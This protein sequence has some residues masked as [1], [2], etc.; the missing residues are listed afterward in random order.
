MCIAIWCFA[1]STKERPLRRMDVAPV[2]L[3][4]PGIGWATQREVNSFVCMPLSGKGAQWLD[5]N[6]HVPFSLVDKQTVHPAGE[7]CCRS[8]ARKN[9]IWQAVDKWGKISGRLRLSDVDFY[10]VTNCVESQFELLSGNK[11]ARLY[12]SGR[13][14]RGSSNFSW[15]PTPRQRRALHS[16]WSQTVIATLVSS[17]RRAADSDAF[18]EIEMDNAKPQIMFFFTNGSGANKSVR[19]FWAVSG[20]PTMTIWWLTESGWSLHSQLNGFSDEAAQFPWHG[21]YRPLA[22]FDINGDGVPNIVVHEDQMNVFWRDILLGLT[23]GKW[24]IIAGSTG[25]ST[26]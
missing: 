25:G 4:S 13:G 9:S 14:Y 6:P 22:V 12:F 24:Q 21:F 18:P 23:G 1:C 11:G 2:A 8:W 26:A 15:Q 3:E 20:G 7:P 16:L 5:S 10:D 19:R 17:R